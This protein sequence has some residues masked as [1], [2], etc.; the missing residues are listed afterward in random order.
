[1]RL[2]KTCMLA[3]TLALTAGSAIAQ[4][5]DDPHARA[6]TTIS[7]KGKRIA[8]VPVA[9][10]FDLTEG[11]AAGLKESLRAAGGDLRHP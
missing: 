11:W 3:A 8:Y 9:M 10:G 2:L 5:I 4:G 6:P 7:F 1:M